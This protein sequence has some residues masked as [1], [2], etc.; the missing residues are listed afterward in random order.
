MKANPKRALFILAVLLAMPAGVKAQGLPN[1]PP[2]SNWDT[3]G[4][5]PAG[6]VNTVTYYSSVYGTNE[7]IIVYTPPGYNPSQKC[8][9]IYG[10]QGIGAGI[11]TIFDDWCVYANVVADNLIGQGIIK[12]VIIVAVNDQI[13]GDPTA[14]TLN[15]VI[16]FIDANYSTY[17]DAD[18]R[19]L[20]GYSWGGM[21]CA[22]VGCANLNTFHY[23]SP[24]SPA[25]FSSGQGTN[26]FPHG[27]PSLQQLKCFLLSC[28]TADWDGFYPPSQNLH[29]FCGSSNIPHGWLP[30]LGA[31]HDAGVWGPA[32]WNFLQMADAAGISTPPCPR[33]AYAQV[34]AVG[35]DSQFGAAVPETCSEGG[36]DVG[37]IGSGCYLAFN[38]VDFGSGAVSFNARVASATGGGNIVIV[39]D[40]TNGTVVGTC[41][42]PGT[43]GWQTWMTQSCPVSGATGIHKVFLE[44]TGG[45]G[46][47][48]D[49]EWWQFTCTNLPAPPVAPTGLA[50]AA[51]N[52]RAALSWV[53]SSNATSYNVKRATVSGGPYTTI[54]NVAGTNYTD[55]ARMAGTNG[56]PASVFAGT[57]YY[58][59]VSALN[60]GGESTNSAQAS[61]IPTDLVPAP[62]M[63]RDV[64]PVGLPGAVNFTN[65]IFT[66][67]GSGADIWDPADAFRFVG[68]TATTQLH[69]GC[70]RYL[71]LGAGHQSV[72]ESRVDDP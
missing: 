37:T 19:G 70:P 59:V 1:M 40:R 48:F 14:D 2:G 17:A 63:T 69:P 51:G 47:L 58:Y 61:V 33:S 66:V 13:N 4:L 34:A 21:Y 53:A 15:C 6:A 42:V 28:G 22:D 45:S 29:D 5:Y 24:S 10:Y 31:G 12:P 23:L 71:S 35:Y 8:G 44:F 60:L 68:L 20:Y 7:Q 38:N 55:V 18:N 3:G 43:G 32:M 16:P 62:W 72:V 67:T 30:V 39:L 26:L 52:E 46:Y 54:A 64:G 65:G 27:A 56:I 25:F 50:G 49:V 9:V 36:Q 11:D 57:N 41:A